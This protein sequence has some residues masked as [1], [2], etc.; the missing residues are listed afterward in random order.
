MAA[1]AGRSAGRRAVVPTFSAL[2]SVPGGAVLDPAGEAHLRTAFFDTALFD[3]AL[4]DTAFLDFADIVV[5]DARAVR[6]R[7]AKL[8]DCPALCRP[9]DP[10]ASRG[11]TR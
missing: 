2:P 11:R 10:V 4:F 8:K 6:R 3:T 1:R 7:A 9:K 5:F